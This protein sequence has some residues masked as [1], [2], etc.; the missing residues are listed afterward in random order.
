VKWQAAENDER[1]MHG[2]VRAE[3]ILV[4]LPDTLSPPMQKQVF[5]KRGVLYTNE[6]F[7]RV[8]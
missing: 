6:H 7:S 4:L 8:R 5:N 1:L 3:G 2:W